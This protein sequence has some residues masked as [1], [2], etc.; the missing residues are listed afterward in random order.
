MNLTE[1]PQALAVAPF[2]RKLLAAFGLGAIAALGHS[3]LSIPL[4]TFG[5]L[6]SLFWLFGKM[7]SHRQAVWL[8]WVSG[9]GYFTVTMSWIVNPFLV[10]AENQGWMAPFALVLLATGLALFWALAFLVAFRAGTTSRSRIVAL[11]FSLTLAEMA[12]AYLLTGFPWGL[13][14]YIWVNG[15]VMQWAAWIGPHGLGA[16]TMAIAA[17]VILF[18][19]AVTGAICAAF[20]FGLVWSSGYLRPQILVVS[21]VS[22]PVWVR[23]V[24]PNAPQ[25]QKW[26]PAFAQT[27][28]ERHLRLTAEPSEHPLD[29]V[30]WPETAVTFW[31]EDTPNKQREIAASVAAETTVV[32]GIVRAQ[33]QRVFNSLVA[34]GSDGSAVRVYDKSHLVPFGEYIPLGDWLDSIGLA[35]F[36]PATGGGFSA[37]P[38][39]RI[40]ELGRAG[41]VLP[42]ICYEAIFPQLLNQNS[43]RPD[44]ILQITNDAWFG[45]LSGPQQHLAQA[46]MR[47]VEQGVPFVR[48]ANTGVSAVIDAYGRIVASLPLGT[49]GKLDAKIPQAHPPT[50]YSRTGDGPLFILM[51]LGLIA[52]VKVRRFI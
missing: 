44:W 47:A 43:E 33:G 17:S 7:N 21:P 9:S 4:L 30:I 16:V 22:D 34:L 25:T 52:V 42:L 14:A 2:R 31:L 5:A 24:Q 38:A 8:G 46:Q 6:V 23:L 20:V 49:E 51:L 10:D 39:P 12:R 41:K 18:R 26:D 48:V 19:N 37:G 15:P 29:L 50:L 40:L 3:P 11:V 35:G 45:E 36:S 1:L 32:L 28:F 27:F 13:L